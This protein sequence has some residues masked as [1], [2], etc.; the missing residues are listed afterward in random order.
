VFPIRKPTSRSRQGFMPLSLRQGVLACMVAV[1]LLAITLTAQEVWHNRAADVHTSAQTTVNLAQSLSQQATDSFQ[2]VDGVL[3]ELVDR[4]ETDGMHPRALRRLQIQM[5]GQVK[6]LRVLHNLFIVDADGNGLVNAL[7]LKNANYRNRAY[8]IFHRTHLTGATHIGH[9]VRSRTDG[10]WIITITRR[11]NHPDGSFAGV[12]L[13]T[14]SGKYFLHLYESVDIG[15]S[16]VITLTLADG[17]ILMRKPFDQ[18]NIGKSIAKS[19]FFRSMRPQITAGTFE[20]RSVIDGVAR[21]GAY[22]RVSRYP[23]VIV[24]GV[25]ADEALAPWRFETLINLIELVGMISIVGILGGYLMRQIG[26]RETAEAQLERLVLVDGLTG[27]GNRHQFEAVLEREWRRAVRGST[28]LAFLMI[29]A[30]EFKAYNDHYGHQAGDNVLKS[31]AGCIAGALGRPADLA[32]R[33]GGE[34]FAVF[35]PDTGSK[36][37]LKVGEVIRCAVMALRIAH[38]GS[39]HG[40]V[41][42]SIG[43]GRM[44]PNGST[45]PSE[46]VKAADSALYEAKSKGRN[47]TEPAAIFVPT[48]SGLIPEAVPEPV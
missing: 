30:D 32:A 18:A 31:I 39:P 33:Y 36:G 4:A 9:A 21:L 3:Q 27:L 40:I 14:I 20:N 44:S 25:A 38:V 28:S 8:F 47:R 13:A 29:D 41:T 34:E 16:G 43:V 35:L 6:Q 5:A 19:G 15:R 46:L 22:H 2:T 7:S 11:L 23:L 37:A 17:T 24:V 12:A 45:A 42:V 48:L 10:S 26:K 1:C